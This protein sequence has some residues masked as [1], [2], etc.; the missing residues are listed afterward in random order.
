MMPTMG[1]ICKTNLTNQGLVEN[2]Q[3]MGQQVFT[4]NLRN[5]VVLTLMAQPARNQIRVT[6]QTSI[7]TEE[8]GQ[9]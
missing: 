9:K 7:K 4:N 8:Q 2:G 3:L 6:I 5:Q 1:I